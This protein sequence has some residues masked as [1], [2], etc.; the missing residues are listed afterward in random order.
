M[1]TKLKD[2]RAQRSGI[3]DSMDFVGNGKSVLG[4]V[5]ETGKGICHL[6]WCVHQIS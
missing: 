6:V 5:G 2:K 4:K 1:Y 3:R